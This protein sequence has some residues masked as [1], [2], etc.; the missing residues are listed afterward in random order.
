[1]SEEDDTFSG[2]N[3]LLVMEI[4]ASEL[5]ETLSEGDDFDCSYFVSYL[6]ISDE[7]VTVRLDISNMVITRM[8][9]CTKWL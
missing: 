7:E 5:D 2:Q 1:M 6:W 8:I 9:C 4:I 3:S